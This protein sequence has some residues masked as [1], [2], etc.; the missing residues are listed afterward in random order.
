MN[1]YYKRCKAKKSSVDYNYN[2]YSTKY[3]VCAFSFEQTT[4]TCSGGLE[5]TV[6]RVAAIAHF[7]L[8]NLLT[9]LLV[10]LRIKI[11]NSAK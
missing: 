2:N 5:S 7:P 10:I 3:T 11:V 6:V 8:G 9:R 4:K 1:Y